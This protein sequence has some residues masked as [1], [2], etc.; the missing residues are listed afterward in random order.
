MS[1]EKQTSSISKSQPNPI[2]PPIPT[3]IFLKSLCPV[4]SRHAT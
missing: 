1:L 3:M 2:I 4:W